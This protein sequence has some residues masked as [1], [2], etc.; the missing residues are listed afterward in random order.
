MKQQ[1]TVSQLHYFMMKHEKRPLLVEGSLFWGLNKICSE[2]IYSPVCTVLIKYFW[3]IDH[4]LP[5]TTLHSTPPPITP[6]HPCPHH[7]SVKANWLWNHS[8]LF[9]STDIDLSLR[10]PLSLRTSSMVDGQRR[11]GFQM[12]W[13]RIWNVSLTFFLSWQAEELWA[14]RLRVLKIRPFPWIAWGCRQCS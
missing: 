8:M 4:L 12:R 13:P 14:F 9:L 2:F 6:P 7:G 5:P 10:F 1:K 11:Q 3:H